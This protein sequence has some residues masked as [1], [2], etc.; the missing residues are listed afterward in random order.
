MRYI[1]C[2]A[3]MSLYGVLASFDGDFTR[4]EFEDLTGGRSGGKRAT[5]VIP[6]S[7]LMISGRGYMP[8]FAPMM[9]NIMKR[10]GQPDA[11]G[12]RK[13]GADERLVGIPRSGLLISG[14]G[15]MPGFVDVVPNLYKRSHNIERFIL[16]P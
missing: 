3:V 2:I 10:G 16:R 4:Y 13:R 9:Q 7:S 14:R 15:W 6:R 1:V 5:V 8:G 12:M 11:D